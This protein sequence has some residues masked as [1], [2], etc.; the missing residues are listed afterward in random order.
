[1]K[2]ER[3]LRFP[4]SL[5][6]SCNRTSTTVCDFSHPNIHCRPYTQPWRQRNS[7]RD[8]EA[9][10]VDLRPLKLLEMRIVWQLLFVFLVLK[11]HETRSCGRKNRFPTPSEK[12]RGPIETYDD[13][14][15]VL[16][17]IEILKKSLVVFYR[18]NKRE[19]SLRNE[20]VKALKGFS[21]V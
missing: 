17:F 21:Q 1:M 8:I 15:S 10:L 5:M 13:P 20:T 16:I 3:E 7:R 6:L 11:V 12:S 18:K 4:I 2:N 19:P 14:S 9:I